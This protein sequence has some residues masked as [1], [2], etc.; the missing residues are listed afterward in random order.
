M[1]EM[2]KKIL[3]TCMY[4]TQLNIDKVSSLVF[5][6]SFVFHLCNL[7]KYLSLGFYSYS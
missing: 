2:K 7:E 6:L 1:I 4:Y 3:W 5:Y